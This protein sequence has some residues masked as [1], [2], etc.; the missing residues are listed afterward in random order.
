MA[1][2]VVPEWLLGLTT[3]VDIVTS[4]TEK[5][6]TWGT[7]YQGKLDGVLDKLS[8]ITLPAISDPQ[9]L[10]PPKKKDNVRG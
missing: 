2:P 6:N 5:L 4:Q 10:A 9:E 3:A 1:I 7:S 8:G